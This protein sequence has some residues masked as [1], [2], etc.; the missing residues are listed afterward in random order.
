MKNAKKALVLLNMGGARSKEELVLF[1]K[2]MFNDENIL[3]MK[4]KRLRSMI[5]SFIISSRLDEAWENY[6]K[7]GGK[8]PLHELTQKLVE[9]LQVELEDEY[10][11]TS[12]MRY[13]KPFA[14]DTFVQL[15]EN[16]IS[17]IVLL[18]LYPQY[19]TTT[20]KSSIDDFMQLVQMDYKTTIITPFYKNDLF[21][22][23]ICEEIKKV[24][25]NQDDYYLIFS[26]H[27][28]PQKMIER[29][30]PYQE[31]IQN[32]VELLKE[33]LKQKGLKF[34]AIHLAYQSKVGPMKWLEPSLD[35]MLE[36][37]K[38]KKVIIYPIA[39]IIDNSET[40]FE[41]DIEYREIAEHIGLKDYKVC[42]CVNDNDTFVKVVK[43]L[44]N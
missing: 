44:V 30:D 16:N 2:N 1:L 8:S 35:Y 31:Q 34:E 22:D 38:D 13:T 7:I 10:F 14:K 36:F 23:A 21:N 9:K 15:K 26:A 27:G 17:E 25:D 42:S 18:P 29:G 43:E 3:T 20:T 39:F 19:S 12:T 24:K 41:L 28:L 33:K 37:F 40:I 4:N 6:E 11:V 32:H 5:A